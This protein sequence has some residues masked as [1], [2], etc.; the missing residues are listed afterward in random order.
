MSIEIYQK[1]DNENNEQVEQG[2]I[3]TDGI[4]RQCGFCDLKFL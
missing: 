4:I 3:S 2:I 1:L